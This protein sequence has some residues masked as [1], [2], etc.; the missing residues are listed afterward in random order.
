MQTTNLSSSELESRWAR[1]KA[2]L[3]AN[4]QH[5]GSQGVLVWKSD[6]GRPN[7]SVRFFEEENGRRVH[8]CIYIGGADQPELLLRTQALLEQYRQAD[9]CTKQVRFYA[10]VVSLVNHRFQL[11]LGKTRPRRKDLGLPPLLGQIR[12]PA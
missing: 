11:L 6:A 5:L 1:I 2:K 8:R 12:T 4:A 10:G 9:S 7:C 3:D